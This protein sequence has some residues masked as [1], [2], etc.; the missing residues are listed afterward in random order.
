MEEEHNES[1][2]DKLKKNNLLLVNKRNT[3]ISGEEDES[4]GKSNSI[5]KIK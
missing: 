2:R 4:E 3:L 1:E 5:E